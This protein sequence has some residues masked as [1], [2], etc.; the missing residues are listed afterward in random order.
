MSIQN[1]GSKGNFPSEIPDNGNKNRNSSSPK[2]KRVGI[3]HHVFSSKKLS[4][5][6]TS[7]TNLSQRKLTKNTETR[8]E[9]LSNLEEKVKGLHSSSQ[10]FLETA[11]SLAERNRKMS[12]QGFFN[13]EWF[14]NHPISETSMKN[15]DVK[16]SFESSKKGLKEKT[17]ELKDSSS[18]FLETVKKL[19]KKY[20]KQASNN[21]NEK[22][23]K[24]SGLLDKTASK[25]EGLVSKTASLKE[26]SSDLEKLSKNLAERKKEEFHVSLFQKFLSSIQVKYETKD[27]NIEENEKVLNAL[28]EIE[29]EVRQTAEDVESINSCLDDCCNCFLPL[30]N[31]FKKIFNKKSNQENSRNSCCGRM[32]EDLLKLKTEI[33][34]FVLG[35]RNSIL[36]RMRKTKL[37]FEQKL[38]AKAVS[39]LLS[40]SSY[41]NRSKILLG[42]IF[43]L[44]QQIGFEC[45]IKNNHLFLKPNGKQLFDEEVEVLSSYIEKVTENLDI[46]S[47][48]ENDVEEVEKQLQEIITKLSSYVNY[49]RYVLGIFK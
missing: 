38:H 33:S 15:K 42:S 29:E 30:R 6:E 8:S 24:V 39:Q 46:F 1:T 23:K 34:Q 20:H 41:E 14:G 35:I 31:L 49:L 40:N 17:E 22:E 19:S 36:K 12:E 9:R 7:T 48:E 3:F 25:K 45:A 5:K 44:A 47:L 28:E 37:G 2:S 43:F 26:N 32:K 10:S 13:R 16:E 21:L 4:T 27:K 18:S 11:Q